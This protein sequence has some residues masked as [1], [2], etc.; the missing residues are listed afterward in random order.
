M[1]DYSFSYISISEN[2]EFNTLIVLL[3]EFSGN[4]NKFCKSSLNVSR[5]LFGSSLWTICKDLMSS[6]CTLNLYWYLIYYF[7]LYD[8]AL[9]V[10]NPYFYRFLGFFRMLS[11][12]K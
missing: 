2:E 3:S 8:F 9:F 11:Y 6:M 5:H 12:K 1:I 7:F 10:C 4:I